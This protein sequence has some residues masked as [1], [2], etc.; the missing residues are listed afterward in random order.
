MPKGVHSSEI[1][2]DLK[3][4]GRGKDAIIADLRARLGG[5]AG[6][7]QHRPADLAPARP[8]AVGRA[9]ADRHQVLRRGPRYA[10]RA[11][12]RRFAQRCRGIAGLADLQVE[13][14]VRIPQLDIIVDYTRAALYGLQ[15][16]AVTEHLERLSN[17]RVVSRLVDGTRRF[18]VVMRL[19]D[20][21]AHHA[22]PRR[23]AARDAL[24][25]GAGAAHRRSP[26]RRRT[27]PDLARER[28]APRRRARQRR[29]LGRA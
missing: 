11:G 29:R 16:Q 19:D 9:G 25:L 13:K 5:A 7:A 14:Q 12:G 10:A 21:A 28:Q 2:V 3:E 15:P 23:S 1:E 20:S 22:G 27:Q 6:L 24:W 17:G 18:D 4:G 26:R 8:Y